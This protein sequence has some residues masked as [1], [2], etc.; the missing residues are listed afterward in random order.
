MGVQGAFDLSK[1]ESSVGSFI[2][3][4]KVQPETLAA[5]F[6]GIANAEPAGAVTANLPSATMSGSKR[7]IG[8]HPRTATLKVTATGVIAANALNSSLRIP[9]MSKGTAWIEGMTGVYQGDTCKIVRIN[10][11]QRN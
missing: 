11:E 10:P 6:G 1:Y 2:Y 3:R 9:I 4:A 7:A 8:V 5:T